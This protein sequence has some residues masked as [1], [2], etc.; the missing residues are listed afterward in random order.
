MELKQKSKQGGEDEEEKTTLMNFKNADGLRTYVRVKD[1]TPIKDFLAA[2][3]HEYRRGLTY[4]LNNV[5]L[6]TDKES[7]ELTENPVL[8]GEECTLV[9][10]QTFTGGFL[11]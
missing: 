3:K 5:L 8:E 9:I 10:Q 11:R 4:K 6:Q 7:G 2:I 1:G